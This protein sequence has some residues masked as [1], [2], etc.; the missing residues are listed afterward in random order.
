[1]P[2]CVATANIHA[3]RKSRHP[4]VAAPRHTSPPPDSSPN[5]ANDSLKGMITGSYLDQRSNLYV[6]TLDGTLCVIRDG[7]IIAKADV[8]SIGVNPA[9]PSMFSDAD[10]TYLLVPKMLSGKSNLAGPI[11]ER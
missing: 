6:L 4:N 8:R 5:A 11:S 1:M 2:S 3:G 10:N 7:Q 9:L